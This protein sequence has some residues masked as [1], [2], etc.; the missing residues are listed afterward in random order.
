MSGGNS[1]DE[2][3]D[4]VEADRQSAQDIEDQ[5]VSGQSHLNVRFLRRPTLYVSDESDKCLKGGGYLD[6]GE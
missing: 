1:E 3:A 5:L 4:M 6:F 2:A